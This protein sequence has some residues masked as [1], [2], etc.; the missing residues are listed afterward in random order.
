MLVFSDADYAAKALRN[1]GSCVPE[2]AV[3]TI[4][5]CMYVFV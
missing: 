2:N 4:Y 5:A 3:G 1:E